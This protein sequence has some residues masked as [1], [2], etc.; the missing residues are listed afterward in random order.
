M[1]TEASPEKTS[2]PNFSKALMSLIGR[3]EQFY[4]GRVY[5]ISN[6]FV[7]ARLPQEKLN[8]LSSQEELAIGSLV[9]FARSKAFLQD[10]AK[11]SADEWETNEL[12]IGRLRQFE[13][14]DADEKS[15]NSAHDEIH[16]VLNF[17]LLGR[18]K[19][20]AGKT[21]PHYSRDVGHIFGPSN[22]HIF[23]PSLEIL[24][25]IV[26]GTLGTGARVNFGSFRKAESHIHLTTNP[27]Q[28]KLHV[29]DIRGKRTAMFGKTRLGKSNAVKL[30]L[31]SMMAMTDK[32][33]NVGQLIFDVNGEYAND[34]PQDGNSSIATIYADRCQVYYLA[35]RSSDAVMGKNRRYIRY[36]FYERTQD[37]CRIMSELLDDGVLVNENL[38]LFLQLEFPDFVKFVLAEEASFRAQRVL[39]KI[40]LM[41]TALYLAG[42]SY[43]EAHLLALTEGRWKRTNLFS[44]G[45]SNN[46]RMAMYQSIEGRVVP[47]MPST[48]EELT[49]EMVIYC[50]FIQQYAND[51]NLMEMGVSLVD[52]DDGMAAR[53]I[54]PEIG[55]GPKMLATCMPYHSASATDFEK[56]IIQSL[57]QGQT[58]IMDLGSANES[59]LRFFSRT[60]SV[61]VF[62]SQEA[63]FVSNQLSDRFVQLYFEEAHMIFP[64]SSPGKVTDIYSRFAKEGAKF[65]IG[66]VYSTQSP[67]TV[68]PE[69]L[70]Q[71]ENFFIGH[72]SN[73]SEVALLAEVQYAFTN[74]EPYILQYRQ[75]GFMHIL[76]YSHRYVVP[77]QVR[78]FNGP[79]ESDKLVLEVG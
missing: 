31:E 5:K 24:N 13:S 66:I 23:Y 67:S 51:P 61:A 8:T 27:C 6:N 45:F 70:S 29:P 58:I 71:T 43:S 15:V 21:R 26:N 78:M 68:N 57:N 36:N 64:P 18:F 25:F 50:K 42:F 46:L 44:T 19:L 9:A 56:D 38:Q 30:V 39:R 55:A 53:F 65:H 72:L 14:E 76:T 49:K 79:A 16:V 35:H 7:H 75:P 3:S 32:D 40:H 12:L 52:K 69:L 74:M 1:L 10:G 47:A 77:V 33:R 37:C 41:W 17:E 63:K 48:M 54:V 28:M 34:N 73:A 11:A 60:L 4:L 2:A 22:W 62:R 20:D 59:V